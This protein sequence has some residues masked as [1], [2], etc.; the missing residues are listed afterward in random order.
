ML[1]FPTQLL[2]AQHHHV[3]ALDLIPEKV[4]LTN[5]KSPISDKEIEDEF[6]HS[7]VI[8]DFDAFTKGNPTIN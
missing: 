8:R 5:N 6:F 1:G 2:L 3:I 7:K 4:D